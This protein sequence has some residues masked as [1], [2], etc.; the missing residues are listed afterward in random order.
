MAPELQRGF[1]LV[2]LMVVVMIIGLMFGVVALQVSGRD[3]GK[4]LDYEGERLRRCLELASQTAWLEARL[5][6]LHIRATGYD[7][8]EHRNGGWQAPRDPPCARHRF[9][10]ELGWSLSVD[11]RRWRP[12]A[13]EDEADSPQLI[14][15]ADGG[16]L[17][18]F[19]LD[20]TL[21]DQDR[22][23]IGN[24]LGGIEVV[25]P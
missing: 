17:T 1:T 19:E 10:A 21:S 7:F 2:E 9:P 20:L 25:N 6:G 8:V 15:D 5:L 24:S 22:R 16:L 4:V 18:P 13:G 3:P 23:L 12:E 11:G 14:V